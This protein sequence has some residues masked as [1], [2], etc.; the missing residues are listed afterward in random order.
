[1]SN[2]REI[3]GAQT[4]QRALRILKL[5]AAH[6]DTGLS[7]PQ[8]VALTGAERSAVQRSLVS[9]VEEGLAQRSVDRRYHLGIDAMHIGRAALQHPPLLERHRFALQKIA[10]LTGDTVFLSV[11]IGDFVLCVHREEGST[12]VRAPRTRVGDLRVLGTSAGGLALLSALPDEAIR[13]IHDRHVAAFEQ[14]RIDLPRL[15]RLVAQTRRAGHAVISDNVSEGVTSIGL[16]LEVPG[17]APGSEPFAAVALS[18]A[19][20]R[21]GADRVLVLQQL[22]QG[23]DGSA[24]S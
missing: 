4:A 7:A 23:V 16:C 9:L 18:A 5:L 13:A 2:S 24:A 1:V 17:Q 8:I 14:A 21:M 3:P 6:H 19:R 22:L 15:R 11:R 12:P 10:R 20:S